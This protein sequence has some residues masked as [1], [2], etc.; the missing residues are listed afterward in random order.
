MTAMQ[1]LEQGKIL[2]DYPI[3]PHTPPLVKTPANSFEFQPC[4]C[5]PQVEYL[6]C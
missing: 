1:R 2:A 4:D 6:T 3:K 5:T